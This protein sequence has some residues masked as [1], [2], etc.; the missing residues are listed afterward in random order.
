MN[1]D[2]NH[3]SL[4]ADMKGW[5]KLQALQY[6][7]ELIVQGNRDTKEILSGNPEAC[8]I[9]IKAVVFG[10]IAFHFSATKRYKLND[11]ELAA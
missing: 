5:T 8:E 3:V 4:L 1:E 10:Y 9:Y 11:L 7:A 2:A 6:L